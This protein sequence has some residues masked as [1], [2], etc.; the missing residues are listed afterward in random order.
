MNSFY[1]FNK[2]TDIEELLVILYKKYPLY[3]QQPIRL[4]HIIAT[5][6]TPEITMFIEEDYVDKQ[7]RD[8]YY[9]YFSQKYSSFNRNCLRLSF[10]E[11]NVNQ[12]NIIQNSV[13]SI[14]KIFIGVIVLRPLTVGNIGTTLLNPQKLKVRGYIQFCK[15]KVMVCGKK[16]FF[17]AFPFFSQDAETMTCAETAIFNLLNYYGHKYADYRILMPREILDSLERTHYERVLPAKGI[18]DEY[19]TKVLSESHLYPRLYSSVN[20]FDELLYAY[21]ESGIPLILGLP[22][23]VV[24]CIGH[25]QINKQLLKAPTDDLIN[26]SQ[27]DN[28][29]YYYINPS[30]FI[31]G[32]IVMDDNGEPY[33]QKNIDILT[34]EYYIQSNLPM[35]MTIVDEIDS[36]E[37]INEV[38]SVS[39]DVDNLDDIIQ[40]ENNNGY[41][42]ISTIKNTYDSIIVPLH[43]RVYIDAARAKEIFTELFLENGLFIKELKNAYLDNSWI[44]TKDN[45]LLWRMF[46]TTS[47]NFKEFKGKT[48][49]DEVMQSTYINSPYPH[50][51]WILE[52][53]T[54]KCYEEGK[55]RV[56]IILD[57][58]SSIHS[59]NRG[60]LS[61]RYSEH[62]VFVPELLKSVNYGDIIA[63]ELKENDAGNNDT[64]KTF[65]KK[66]LTKIFNALYT[67]KC[68]F[69][70][71]TFDIFSNTNLKEV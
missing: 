49:G 40:S 27:V 20:D 18:G 62:Y 45:P 7:Y 29:T 16:I 8:T 38:D 14:Q 61:I 43:R 4:K 65:R 25:G 37:Q 71:S 54:I 53:G 39:F 19:I 33:S 42:S 13:D 50:F 15:Y 68:S 67:S 41:Y 24:I 64:E 31:D 11:G 34:K 1:F 36:M 2:E 51:I 12:N 6:K 63:S 56:E 47:S 28:C 5:I 58:T 30:K 17:E 57:A 44:T 3:I 66:T 26:Y 60:I 21:I 32:Y 23:H 9:S 35:Q 48:Y 10:F 52:L 22:R 59:A 46:L 55:A 70:E 69:V